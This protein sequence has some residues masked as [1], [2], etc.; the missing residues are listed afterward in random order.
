MIFTERNIRD[1]NFIIVF[2][3]VCHLCN[4]FVN[5]LIRNDRHDRLRFSTLQ[6]ASGLDVNN[7]MKKNISETDSIALVTDGKI[8]FRSTAVLRT[9][10]RLGG[11]WKLFY[12]FTIVPEPL[13]DWVYDVV[14]KNRY[15]WFG[16]KDVC[17]VPDEK[18][19]KKFIVV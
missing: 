18:A 13:R 8:Y 2:D 11:G 12:V 6:S 15:K 5:F 3:G 10:R 17:M 16:R 1:G 19:K 14:A 4:S 9:M 7:E